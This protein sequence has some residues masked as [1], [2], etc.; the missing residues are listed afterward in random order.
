[1]RRIVSLF[2]GLMVMLLAMPAVVSAEITV[3]EFETGDRWTYEV[4][5]EED[6][7]EF[8]GDWTFKVQG[9]KTV[10]G[11]EVYDLS[12]DGEGTVTMEIP[13]LGTAT[14]DF[15]VDG[16][17]YVRI[18]DLATVAENM[19]LEMSTSF[20]G[21]EISIRMFF[22]MTYDPPLNDFGFPLDVAKE[23]TSASSVTTTSTFAMTMGGNTTSETNTDTSSQTSGFKCESK[24]STSVPAGTFESYKINQSEDDDGYVHSYVSEKTG[25]FVK[26]EIYDENGEPGGVMEL[27]SYSY[28]AGQDAIVLMDYWWLILLII[29][30]VAILAG[31]AS[32]RS[33]RSK[34]EY[35][36]PPPEQF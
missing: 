34:E 14:M 13:S 29:I 2:V 27:K 31:V 12:L 21:L 5:M 22:E 28:G 23:W 8:N 17:H 20:F 7:M 33:R 10:V 19:T 25:M 15:T 9:E 1:M 18:S 36:P 3:P 32:V 24:E 35:P 26:S 16:Y 6:G 11:H 4:T 30:V